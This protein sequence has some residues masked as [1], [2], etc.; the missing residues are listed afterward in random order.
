MPNSE[1]LLSTFLSF[2]LALNNFAF[3]CTNYI[4][5]KSC[6]MGIMLSY[7]N[8]FT[9]PFQKMRAIIARTRVKAFRSAL[10]RTRKSNFR[11]HVLPI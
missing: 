4:Q 10:N 6:V 5:T 2:L 9:R 8:I 7:A 3:N 1:T 11:Q